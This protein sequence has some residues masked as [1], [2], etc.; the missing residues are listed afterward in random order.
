MATAQRDD[1]V[2]GY[3]FLVTLIDSGGKVESLFSSLQRPPLG[4][5]SECS[6]LE[7]TMQPE[8][9]REGGR[10]GA[11][12]KFANRVTWT[13]IRLRRGLATSNALW[14]WHYALVEGRVQRRDGIITL[15]N[16]QRRPIRIW[17]FTRGLPIKWNGPALNANQGQVAIEELEIAHEGMKLGAAAALSLSEVGGALGL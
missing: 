16:D 4:G 5:F 11:V 7:M 3:N 8:E 15:Q 9:Y 10:N 1:P 2:L 12:L 6:G 17:R 13:N 14:D